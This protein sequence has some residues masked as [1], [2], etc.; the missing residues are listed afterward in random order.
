[1]SVVHDLYEEAIRLYNAG[2]IEGFANLHAEDAVLVTPSGTVKG[3]A[4]ICGYWRDLRAAFPDLTLTVDLAVE[5]NDLIATEWHES[6]TNTGPLLL[7]DGTR[8][9]PTGKR[10]GHSG[11]GL[12]RVRDGK[13][14]EC[15][16]SWDRTAVTPQLGREPEP[17][18][19]GADRRS[20]ARRFDDW[21]VRRPNTPVLHAL[22]RLP[23]VLWRLGLGPLITHVEVRR[24]HL[25]MLTVT[26]RSSGLPRHTPVTAHALD[27]RTYLWCPYG[28]RSQ[29]YRN[30]K[31]NPVVRV[32]SRRGSQVMR[33]VGIDDA[34][35]AAAVVA[36]LRHFD[37]TFLRS[38][39]NAEGIADT[40]DGIAR[41]AR[42]LHL[43]RLE[44][45]QQDGPTA[46]EAH[47][48]WLWFVPVAVAAFAVVRRC[49]SNEAITGQSRLTAGS[50][51]SER[52]GRGRDGG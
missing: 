18:P 10:I 31:A 8:V 51:F 20:L 9:A 44:P 16:V 32:Q 40:S 3:R 19:V 37:E 11:M 15:H 6:G 36:E 49:R 45:I 46:L 23:I 27:G 25:V 39:L 52:R 43:R 29:W 26:G 21:T 48:A 28:A 34:D 33:A 47:L 4:A 24:G 22:L 2:D 50:R 12:A 7:R 1:M 42:R 38:Y 35:E 14:V 5:Q 17:G 13:F 30:L 41:N